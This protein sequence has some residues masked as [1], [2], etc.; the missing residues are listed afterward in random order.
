MS[1][2]SGQ[3]VQKL[4]LSARFET[5]VKL[6]LL[7]LQVGADGEL[8]RFRAEQFATD[9]TAT[10]PD[11]LG[12]LA[13]DRDGVVAGAYAQGTLSFDR[14][15]R[16]PSSI[17]A[18]VR[19]DVYH[20]GPVTLL[21][22]DPRVLFR[23]EPQRWL[24]IHGGFGL[25]QQPPSFPVPLP[26]IDTY[27]LQL[28]LQ[29]NWQ[30]SLGLKVKLPEEFTVSATG[31][32]GKFENINDVVI[33]YVA[34]G[35][36][37]PPPESLSGLPA[38]VTRQVQ[39]AGYGMELLVRRHGGHWTGWLSYTLS[40]AERVYSCGLGPSDFDQAHVLNA[41]VQVRLPWRLMVGMRVSYST[42]RPYTQL[43]VD[44]GSFTV[45]GYRNNAR[46]PSYAQLDLRIDRE[47]IFARWALAVFIEA[48]NLTYSQ[49]VFGVT[50]P[51]SPNPLDPS[52]MITRYDTP[53]VQGFNWILPSVGLRGR[54]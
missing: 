24:E 6:P 16:V 49:S 9:G 35:C 21:G 33:D 34:S 36:T 39:G 47:W 1:V 32:Y 48:L 27:A 5:R 11:Q 12:D 20:A 52:M 44:T 31:Y 30:G 42:G 15:L 19:A 40:R 43:S 14:W 4:G 25:Y 18:G 45:T 23:V 38:Y 41:V 46:L 17:T 22:I 28:G 29:R 51:K 2:L 8:S 53:Q 37:S 50:Y 10:A 3:G 7:A 13:G 54:F 26:G